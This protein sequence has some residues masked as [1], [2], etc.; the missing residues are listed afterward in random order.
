MPVAEELGIT[1]L[2]CSEEDSDELLEE[3]YLLQR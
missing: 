1:L 3:M 2:H